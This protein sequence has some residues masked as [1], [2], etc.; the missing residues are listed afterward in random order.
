[1][2][3]ALLL[4]DPEPGH[5]GLLERQLRRDGFDVVGAG[6]GGDVLDLAELARPDLV[7][8]SGGSAESGPL[9]LCARL[10][11]PTPG[12]SWNRDVPVILLGGAEDDVDDRVRALQRGA[13]DYVPEPYAYAELLERIRAVLRRAS[14]PQRHVVEA[15]EIRI[16]GRTRLATVN[17]V[18][19]ALSHKEF[20]LLVRLAADPERV[21]TKVELL[22]DVWGVNMPGVRTRTVESHASRLRRKLAKHGTQDYVLNE[23]GVGYRL[24]DARPAVPPALP[25][26]VAEVVSLSDRRR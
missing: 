12:R 4:A 8:V 23:W 5:R 1:M 17:D 10:R 6:L 16:D 21:F 11:N 22:R 25:G 7:I 20:A 24:L 15:G 26:A 13:D 3:T 19:V 18:R 2:S 14:R 9:D